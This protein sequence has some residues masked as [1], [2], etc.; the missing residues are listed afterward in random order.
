MSWGYKAGGGNNVECRGFFKP[1][2]LAAYE[3]GFKSLFADRQ[4]LLNAAAYYYDYKDIQFNT[5]IPNGSIISNAGSATALGVE[6]EYFLRPKV[7]EG[8]QFDGSVSFEASDYGAGCFNDPAR[9]A[10]PVPGLGPNGE[11]PKVCPAGVA[12]YAQIKGNDLIRAPRWKATAGAQYALTAANGDNWLAR[13]DAVYSD[14]VYQDIFNGQAKFQS[15]ATQPSYW[16]LSARVAWAS[17]DRRYGVEAFVDN[18]TNTYYAT[19]RS[20]ANTPSS[21]VR[22]GGNLGPPRTYGV[23]L[24]VKLGSEAE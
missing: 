13:F 14:K 3:V 21:I 15:A 20:P 8:L 2:K 19:N 11:V 7:V 1:E 17:P 24:R 18:I 10:G 23:R 5:F 6:V 4:V 12:D 9:L 22:V 16:L